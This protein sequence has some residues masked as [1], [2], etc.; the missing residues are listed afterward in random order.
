[1]P[2]DNE[3]LT[4]HILF[5]LMQKILSKTTQ[6]SLKSFSVSIGIGTMIVIVN[7][8]K[9]AQQLSQLI[10]A[11]NT[12]VDPKKVPD[13]ASAY[14]LSDGTP[15]KDAQKTA[16]KLVRGSKP[17]LGIGL[18]AAYIAAAFG[19]SIKQAKPASQERVSLKKPCPLLLD[20]KRMFVV[21]KDSKYGID[22]VPEN[23]VVM[24][25]SPKYDYEVI[26]ENQSPFFGVAFNPELGGEGRLILTNFERFV[27]MWEKYHR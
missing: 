11:K 14:I 1:M 19:A 21:V 5:I 23:F 3:K 7:N 13:N 26:M 15:D 24:A 10:R 17:V 8:G 22:E 16:E 18:G 20:L 12:V 9:G 25:S 27:E 4:F 6:S 2:N